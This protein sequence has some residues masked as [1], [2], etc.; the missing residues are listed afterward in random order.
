MYVSRIYL[1]LLR[2]GFRC[3]FRFVVV[4]VVV[5]IVDVVVVIA[6]DAYI[7]AAA[8]TFDADDFGVTDVITALPLHCHCYCYLYH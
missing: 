1:S 6:F 8:I 2:F 3:D 5:V 7:A 4:V